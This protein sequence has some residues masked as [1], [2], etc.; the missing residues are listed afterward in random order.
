MLEALYT[1][2]EIARNFFP[3]IVSFIMRGSL[4]TLCFPL[5]SVITGNIIISHAA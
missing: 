1:L 2:P 5:L 3:A 4:A